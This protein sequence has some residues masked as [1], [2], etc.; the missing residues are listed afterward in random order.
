MRNMLRISLAILCVGIVGFLVYAKDDEPERD[1]DIKMEMKMDMDEREMEISELK[2][3]LVE[4]EAELELL[5]RERAGEEII[6]AKKVEMQKLHEA[7]Q[8]LKLKFTPD[9]D[10][11]H[12]KIE[13]LSS[14][15]KAIEE[16]YR[17]MKE[18]Y[19][20]PE[21]LARLRDEIEIRHEE[22]KRLEE[23]AGSHRKMMEDGRHLELYHARFVEAEHLVEIIE[24]FLTKGG[25][26]RAD[27]RTNHVIVMDVPIGVERAFRIMKALDIPVEGEMLERFEREDDKIEVI[28]GRI[29]EANAKYVT[30]RE[31]EEEETI[32]VYVPV[33]EAEADRPFLD[34][35]LSEIAASLQVGDRVRIKFVK[36]G[37]TLWIQDINPR[38]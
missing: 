9:G 2:H 1:M 13:I 29:I 33:R 36:G 30:I 12:R 28:T 16:K 18:V 34:E 24:D 10:D 31:F 3:K 26:I 14:E 15:L 20:P 38:D 17:E 5:T 21:E 32:R 27:S 25:V 23:M 35:R 4:T 19:A 11:I 37:D 7:L 6:Q 8:R 22:L